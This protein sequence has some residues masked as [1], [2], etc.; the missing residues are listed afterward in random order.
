MAADDI[1]A[2]LAD[3]LELVELAAVA[4]D[5][6]PQAAVTSSSTAAAP[7]ISA[8]LLFKFGHAFY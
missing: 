3:A 8:D 1:G 6:E 2:E 4:L 5:F 7:A